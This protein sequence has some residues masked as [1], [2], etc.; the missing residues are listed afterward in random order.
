VPKVVGLDQADAAR[1]LHHA[2][3]ALGVISGIPAP[4]SPAGHV[5]ATNPSAGDTV[6]PGAIVS[7][8]ISS[9]G[10]A[11]TPSPTTPVDQSSCASGNV[12]T[13]ESTDAS[14]ICVTVG[15]TLRVTFVSSEGW[16]GYGQW[17]SSP[18]TISDNS[19][20]TGRSYRSSGKKATAS[21]GAAGT[22]TATVTAQFD[23]RCSP[24]DTT[25]CTVPPQALQV[26]TVTVVSG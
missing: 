16:S 18:P 15:S 25:P 5:I 1:S 17:S 4:R 26:L 12:A 11:A 2:G 10:I 3:L 23:V 6:A 13:T 9:G 14:S 7:M 24:A 20:L 22:G 19:V 8:T 21:F